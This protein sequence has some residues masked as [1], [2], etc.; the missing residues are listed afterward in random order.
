MKKTILLTAVAA[1]A[2]LSLGYGSAAYANTPAE[3][4][5]IKASSLAECKKKAI[6]IRAKKPDAIVWCTYTVTMGNE[7][8]IRYPIE[9][10]WTGE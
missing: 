1:A 6:E 3:E 2:A 7:V 4:I 10:P 9:N 8:T 5:K